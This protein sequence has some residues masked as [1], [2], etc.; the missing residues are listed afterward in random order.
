MQITALKPGTRSWIRISGD[1]VEAASPE[2]RQ[3]MFQACPV[4]FK[5][6]AGPEDPA[7][8]LFRIAHMTALLCTD[9]G[10]DILKD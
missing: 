2:E 8:A 7:F 9:Q 4:L 10:K 3:A 5:R 6:F 1:A